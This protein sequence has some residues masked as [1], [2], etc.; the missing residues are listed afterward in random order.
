MPPWLPTVIIAVLCTVSLAVWIRRLRRFNDD[1]ND[2]A[3]ELPGDFPAGE[4]AP[5]NR[6]S[7]PPVVA[8][9]AMIFAALW[10]LYHFVL[11]VSAMLANVEPPAFN[12]DNT[13]RAMQ[14]NCW[15][16]A[17]CSAVGWMLV[18][19][20]EHQWFNAF[21]AGTDRL[22]LH[23]RNGLVTVTAAWLPVFATIL[24][25]LPL[26]TAER[27]HSVLQLLEMRSSLEI[28]AWAVLS[29]VVVAPLFEELVFRVILQTSLERFA[30]RAAIPIAAVLFAG[31][32]RFPDSLAI[33]P[34]A[35]VLGDAYQRRRSYWEIV[36][37][38]GAFNAVMLG[39]DAIMPHG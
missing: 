19:R 16:L 11:D 7:L 25:T 12:P 23:L 27:Q 10:I 30:G 22:P 32:H 2:P 38:H 36:A 39:L 15:L 17:A 1:A 4:A 6:P 37:A 21:G 20:G 24:L 18:T 9:G 8:P 29:A 14:Q 31:V 28:Y 5:V 35:L 34:L 33:V 26:R 13:L 3:S